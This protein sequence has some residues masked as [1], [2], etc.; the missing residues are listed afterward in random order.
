M[1]YDRFWNQHY[2]LFIFLERKR[3]FIPRNFLFDF[4]SLRISVDS[5]MWNFSWDVKHHQNLNKLSHRRH[6]KLVYLE[7]TTKW[8][9]YFV[10]FCKFQGQSLLILISVKKYFLNL[11]WWRSVSYRTQS[12]DLQSKSMDWFLCD[13][14]FSHERVKTLSSKYD[15]PY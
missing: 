11:S 14:E 2:R 13:R 9:D 10:K 15:G 8:N 6:V 7:T 3:S 12:I 4:T 5:S 1:D